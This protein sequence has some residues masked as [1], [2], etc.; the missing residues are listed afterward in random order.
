[1]AGL[2]LLPVVHGQ[3]STADPHKPNMGISPHSVP[4]KSLKIK[5]VPAPLS[6][7]TYHEGG[8]QFHIYQNPHY[9]D[10]P[11]SER[12]VLILG[13]FSSRASV[14]DA[15]KAINPN[16]KDGRPYDM[17]IGMMRE[18]PNPIT[19]IAR[20]N[21][22]NNAMTPPVPS[23]KEIIQSIPERIQSTIHNAP[24]KI[25]QEITGLSEPA[26]TSNQPS[27]SELVRA[28][29]NETTSQ[30]KT[31]A[32]NTA[33]KAVT[34]SSTVPAVIMEA[35]RVL[36][37]HLSTQNHV[38]ALKKV[39][40]TNYGGPIEAKTVDTHSNGTTLGMTALQDGNVFKGVETVNLMGPDIGLNAKYVDKEAMVKL[41][42]AGVH[43]VRIHRIDGDFI[44]ELG[45][46]SGH[47]MQLL[48]EA[49]VTA[50]DPLEIQKLA[51]DLAKESLQAYGGLSTAGGNP[52]LQGKLQ[53]GYQQYPQIG[54]S[55]L[56]QNHA[57]KNYAAMRA[58][59]IHIEDEN[60][61]KAVG[62]VKIAIDDQMLLQMIREG[63]PAQATVPLR[64]LSESMTSGKSVQEQEKAIGEFLETLGNQYKVSQPKQMLSN[65]VAVSVKPLLAQANSFRNHWD[66]LPDTLKY[67]GK[68]TR[69][70]GFVLDPDNQNVVLIG[71]A[72]SKGPYLSLDDI[73]TGLRSVLV[74]KTV[75]ACSL[76]P[77]PDDFGGPQYSRVEGV[78]KNSGFAKTMLD[79]DYD[80]K[81]LTLG[82]DDLS[83]PS[84]KPFTLALRETHGPI[85]GIASRFWFY[86]V[87]PQPGSIQLSD[88]RDTVLFLSHMQVLSEEMRLSGH[89]LIGTGNTFGPSAET[90]MSLT[91][92]LDAVVA[93]RPNI[94]KLEGLFDIVLMSSL[95]RSL[96]VT[97]PVL[98]ELAGLPYQ[99][100]N[101]PDFYEG[102]S[103]SD[104]GIFVHGGVH[105]QQ[106][107]S[108]RAI[109]LLDEP[110][111][112]AIR[113]QALSA[114]RSGQLSVSLKG[115]QVAMVDLERTRDQLS[116]KKIELLHKTVEGKS[117]ETLPELNM[118]LA[119]HSHDAEL[120]ILRSMVHLQKNNLNLAKN[121]IVRARD[122]DS[123]N[124][125]TSIKSAVLLS[126]IYSIEG[127]F[128]QAH[129]ELDRALVL[130]DKNALLLTLKGGIYKD[131]DKAQEARL[132]LTKAL[133]ADPSFA[134]AYSIRAELEAQQGWLPRA[135]EFAQKAYKLNPD[136]ME[137]KLALSS[138]EA[139]LTHF[140]ESR[141]L[142]QE[143][144]AHPGASA[145]DKV[146]AYLNLAMIAGL[147]N[148]WFAFRDFLEH[149]AK[150]LPDSILPLTVGS[151]Y[152]LEFGNL[153]LA[154]ELVQRAKLLEPNSPLV[155][156]LLQKLP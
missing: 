98:K 57:V 62:G 81:K 51:L 91:Q 79:A 95:L 116:L 17:V 108:K 66:Q 40:Q 129:Q 43:E 70:Y 58:G 120:L 131:Q 109:L 113:Q 114:S 67:P 138:T 1:M 133:Q 2:L 100:E 28:K 47:I 147:Q 94:Q 125:E 137:V 118:L 23:T 121:D 39:V 90:A 115:L 135:K 49:G 21:A 42:N 29:I 72:S 104:G 54:V 56:F 93:Q 10:I 83:L 14:E 52:E 18:I 139:Y 110:Q 148:D 50:V 112:E 46:Y 8:Y 37:D 101:V 136:L 149:A 127:H 99:P 9:R 132:M 5:E 156:S 126:S 55:M 12:G 150:E 78:P 74:D 153:S 140:Q 84:F 33:E 106:A 142:S 73:T 32:I 102:L 111:M 26:N 59:L 64:R 82:L 143:V 122:I 151:E 45:V 61:D 89:G 68:I 130:D 16:S 155:E 30:V 119:E 92:N 146:Q 63:K 48:K 86:P 35:T 24:D 96:N 105:L 77:K 145:M 34:M 85:N 65:L 123:D 15:S 53:I 41:E 13:T 7:N 19:E 6:F 25:I 107:G 60:K 124:P 44:T 154:T 103:N 27:L 80:M 3:P 20:N 69:I 117:Q 38:D 87:Q 71:Q 76:D 144:L 36:G 22:L 88:T 75:P 152:A 31:T 128:E 97:T 141:R 134:L 4:P 11:K